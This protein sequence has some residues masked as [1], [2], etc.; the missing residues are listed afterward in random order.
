MRVLVSVQ[1]MTLYT[2]ANTNRKFPRPVTSKNIKPVG[3]MPL[4]HTA[5]S[6]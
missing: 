3:G 5:K 4:I 2:A 6:T 1:H